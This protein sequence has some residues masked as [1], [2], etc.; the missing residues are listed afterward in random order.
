VIGI[1]SP[2]VVAVLT[3]GCAD[4]SPQASRPSSTTTHTS[5]TRTTAVVPTSLPVV[6]CP[7]AWAIS[8]PVTVPLPASVTTSVPDALVTKLA[9]Y[10]DTDEIMMLLAPKG[11]TCTASYGADG[12]GGVDLVPS[13]A[14][15]PTGR[16]G[17]HS[18]VQAITGFETGGSPVQAAAEACPY[19]PTAATALESD[20]EH[21][22]SPPP[23]SEKIERISASIVAFEDPPGVTGA[24]ALSGGKNPA[25]GVATYSPDKGPGYF[26]D[27]CTIPQDE[28]T[29]CTAA[30]DYFIA[31]YG[32]G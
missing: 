30:L 6:T 11:W 32:Q 27:T 2:L 19:F 20:L 16:V 12:S 23:A 13:G 25:N 5:A 10:S 26:I 7:T 22:C 24:G 18:S 29:I 8:T 4:S 14:H 28:H 17:L 21:G 9:V 1:I 3:A 15:V 31:R